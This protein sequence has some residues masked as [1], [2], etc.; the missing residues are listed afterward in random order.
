MRIKVAFLDENSNY[1][2]RVTS[3]FNNK[4]SD[5]LEIYSFSEPEVAIKSLSENRMSNT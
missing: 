4:F 2:S 3:V 1:L 5:K